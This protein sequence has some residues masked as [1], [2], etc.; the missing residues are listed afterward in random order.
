V[1]VPWRNDDGI[2]TPIR[3]AVAFKFN[4]EFVLERTNDSNASQ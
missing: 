1:N 4:R 3:R 2:V